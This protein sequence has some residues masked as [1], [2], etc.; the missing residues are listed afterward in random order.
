MS[1]LDYEVTNSLGVAKSDSASA[2]SFAGEAGYIIGFTDSVKLDI[3]YSQSSEGAVTLFGSDGS[4]SFMSVG[5][6]LSYEW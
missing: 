4:F 1:N 3:R 5:G 2:S 6:V